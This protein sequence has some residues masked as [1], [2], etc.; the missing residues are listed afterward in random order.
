MATIILKNT[1]GSVI[2]VLG[3]SIAASG[4]DDFTDES[5]T[6]LRL[7]ATLIAD[8]ISGDIVVN[9]GTDDLDATIGQRFVDNML[10]T[11]V[12][13]V[14]SFGDLPSSPSTDDFVF[15][16]PFQDWVMYDGTHWASPKKYVNMFDRL[17]KIQTLAYM[18]SGEAQIKPSH[19]ILVPTATDFGGFKIYGLSINSEKS[20]TADI[21]LHNNSSLNNPVF[22]T[23][24]I[25]SALSVTANVSGN[26]SFSGD[27]VA[28]G[29]L[30]QAFARVTAG[31]LQDSILT[32]SVSSIAGA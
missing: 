5:L 27:V 16:T 26:N 10:T 28:P 18:R 12:N 7:D 13:T 1:T 8:I 14:T 15:Y 4:Q 17:G 25:G 22:G 6:D 11:F 32:I 3:R 23:T 19:G 24:G 30:L 31:T 2:Y 20:F 21:E 29:G 9:D